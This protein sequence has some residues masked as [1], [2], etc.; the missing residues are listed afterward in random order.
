MADISAVGKAMNAQKSLAAADHILIDP[1]EAELGARNQRLLTEILAFRERSPE[2]VIEALLHLGL[3]YVGAEALEAGYRVDVSQAAFT[4][5]CDQL[6]QLEKERVAAVVDQFL[7][8][9]GSINLERGGSLTGLWA[10]RIGSSGIGP[11]VFTDRPGRTFLRRMVDMLNQCVYW[12]MSR[13]KMG[14]FGNDFARG[15][16]LLRWLGFCQVS[17]NPVLAWIAYLEDD[18]LKAKLKAEIAQ[19]DDWVKDPERHARTIAL[20]ATLLAIEPNLEVFRPLAIRSKL[21]DFM[22]SLQLNP[23]ISHRA[24]ASVEDAE[25]AFNWAGAAAYD[26]DRLLG[27]EDPGA[28]NP[29]IVFKVG[30]NH[31]KAKQIAYDLNR[32]GIPTNITIV[33]TVGQEIALTIAALEGKAEAVRSGLTVA[34]GYTTSMGG[35]LVSHLRETFAVDLFVKIAKRRGF[36]R[37]YELLGR[38]ARDLH[39]DPAI[40]ASLAK[41]DIRTQAS[42]VCAYQYLK[43]LDTPTILN[44][45][46]ELNMTKTDVYQREADFQMAGTLV[47][48]RVWQTFFAPENRANWVAYLS[49]KFGIT[50]EQAE[51]VLLSIDC[52]PA[53][54]RI[55][56]DTLL[57][58]G[59]NMTNTEFPNHARAVQL[60][61]ERE[62][63]DLESYQ[64]SIAAKSDPEQVRRLLEI[65]DF[66]RA[67]ELTPSLRGLLRHVGIDVHGCGYWG[68]GP[69]SWP[70]FGSCQKTSS[71]FQTAFLQFVKM[72]LDLAKEIA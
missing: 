15:L 19:H 68:L 20:T 58:Q 67:Y 13:R 66:R 49:G 25:R 27:V 30:A 51:Q 34:R 11:S 59:P 16:R 21:K 70:A 36:A 33:Y 35:R 6:D 63:F 48:Q 69:G 14:K 64:D 54:K 60:F 4:Q 61:A 23:E 5:V 24:R 28:I 1:I 32:M 55:P 41:M 53:S 43:S 17:T 8:R 3:N 9:M 72:C 47:V 50:E 42:I 39:V 10:E 56:E 65:R 22:V 52:L 46:R 18:A 62:G 57:T 71:E 12:Q 31:L 37:A 40:L 29:C 2:L 44:A 7:A 45:A 38:L 26:Y